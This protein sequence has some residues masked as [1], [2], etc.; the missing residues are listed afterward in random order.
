MTEEI[1]IWRW[2][3]TDDLDGLFARL[4]HAS[5]EEFS[6][7]STQLIQDGAEEMPDLEQV[8]RETEAKFRAMNLPA[9]I[10]ETMLAGFK[11]MMGEAREDL[12]EEENDDDLAQ[13][14]DGGV[15]VALA[16]SLMFFDDPF[17]SLE[18]EVIDGQVAT[19]MGQYRA[20]VSKAAGSEGQSLAAYLG[21]D[22]E[23]LY[24]E[25]AMEILAE[26]GLD[27][28]E[29]V[30]VKGDMVLYLSHWHEDKEL[31]IDLEFGRMPVA[32]FDPVKGQF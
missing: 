6:E 1:S 24:D 17:A 21:V 20:S 8:E 2:A 13:A 9:D 28:V 29:W 4:V 23:Q 12:D 7:I 19:L 31:P 14:P 10:L 22:I 27:S 16:S 25:D 32:H 18:Y 11:S 15:R 5:D 30:W 3:I 26:N